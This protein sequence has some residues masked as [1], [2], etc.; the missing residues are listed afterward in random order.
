MKTFREYQHTLNK[1]NVDKAITHD[2]AT[3]IKHPSL[4][5]EEVF[6]DGHHL[7]K[8]GSIDEYYINHTDGKQYTFKAEEI[9]VTQMQEHKHNPRPKKKK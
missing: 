4:G 1:S 5:K 8:D 2:W 6:V 7:G 3:H 9:E